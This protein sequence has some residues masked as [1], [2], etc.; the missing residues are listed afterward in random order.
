MP[1]AVFDTNVLISGIVYAG[2]SKLLI[3]AILEGKITLIISM[4]IIREFRRVIIRDKFKLSKNQQNI[5]T[6]FVLR[7]GNIVKVKSRFKVVKQDPNDD[8]I[9]RTAHD[10]KADYIVSGDEHLL[11]L[12]EFRGIKIVTVS[13]MLELLK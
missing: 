13:E 5:I 11:S 1:K 10:G 7:I 2:K 12:K 9:L 8:R 6:N 3:D 4:Q